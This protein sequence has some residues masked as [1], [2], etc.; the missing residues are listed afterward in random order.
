[1]I[2]PAFRP[3]LRLWRR[4]DGHHKTELSRIE[5]EFLNM[6]HGITLGCYGM[7][8]DVRIVVRQDGL[9]SRRIEAEQVNAPISE[10][11]QL[12]LAVRIIGAAD[13]GAR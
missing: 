13:N 8:M 4:I 1:M 7:H 10:V 11:E 5:R 3:G 2:A 12:V 9:V 6:P